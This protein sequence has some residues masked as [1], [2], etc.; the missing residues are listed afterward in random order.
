MK[1]IINYCYSP[2]E[3]Y[4]KQKPCG[5]QKE[6]IKINENIKDWKTRAQ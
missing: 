6:S 1:Y 3:Y 2:L 5:L 4:T